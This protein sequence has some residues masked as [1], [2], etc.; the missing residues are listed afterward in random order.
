MVV[1]LL[2]TSVLWPSLQRDFLL[3]LA[4]EGMYRPVWSAEILA[5]LEYEEARKLVARHGLDH[6]DATQ[7]AAR[8]VATMRSA[9]DDAEVTGWE[10]RVGTYA[11]P[12]PDDEHVLAAAVVAGAGALVTSND[13]DFPRDKLPAAVDVLRPAE[14]AANT[15]ALSP[16]AAA[17]AVSELAARSGR[18]GRSFTVAEVLDALVHRY[19]MDEAVGY[20]R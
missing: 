10:P 19:G 5:E 7:S 14:F 8:L 6:S 20:L 15:V 9:F 18:H 16:A 4:A 12:D 17:R 1:A 2:D 11:L 13:K 3:S